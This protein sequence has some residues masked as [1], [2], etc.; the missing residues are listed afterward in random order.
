MWVYHNTKEE[1]KPEEVDAK[2]VGFI[3]V[4]THIPTNRKYIGKKLLTRAKTRQVKGK[5]KRI[6]VESD[7][8]TYWGS[9]QTLCEEVKQNGEDQYCR[10]ILHLCRT[11]TELSY[12]ETWE[13]FS[14]NVLLSEN[15]YNEWVSCKIR[16]DQLKNSNL[17]SD[18]ATYIPDIEKD[19]E[20]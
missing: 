5:K 7:W 12:L 19:T 9:N 6:R 10:E 1:F 8:K 16:K 15:Y 20:K 11:R 4:I 13:I 18:T 2:V 3:Y 14:R 17:K